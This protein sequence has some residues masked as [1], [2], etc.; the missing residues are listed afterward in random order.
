MHVPASTT[1]SHVTEPEASEF[2]QVTVGCQRENRKMLR[3]HLDAT[4]S[5]NP[6][7]QAS[8]DRLQLE[9]DDDKSVVSGSQAC[10]EFGC[11]DDREPQEH[12][13]EH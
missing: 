11:E 3:R 10:S 12:I 7:I 2:V 4:V 6:N 9:E 5:R 8:G 13:L 1:N